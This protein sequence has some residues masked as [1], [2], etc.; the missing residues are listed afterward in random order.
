MKIALL[1]LPQSGKKTLFSLMTG[2]E[3]PEHRNEGDSL[4]GIA[5]IRDPRVDVLTEMENPEKTKYAENKIV[6]C[7]DMSEGTGK[8]EWLDAARRCDLLCLVVRDFASESVYHPSGS[9]DAARDRRALET[10]LL[11]ADLELIEKRLE[12][13]AKEKRSGLT[14][15]QQKEEEVLL[16]CREAVE[17]EKRISSLGFGEE[18]LAAIR[19]LNLV[20]L[21]PILWILNVEEERVGTAEPAGEDIFLISA[22]IEKEI[23]GIEETEERSEYLA[24]LGLDSSGLDRLNAAA[25]DALGLMSFYTMGKDEVRAWTIRKGSLAPAAGGKIHSDIERG[26]IRVEV[27]KYDDLVAAG[28]ESA[29]KAQGKALL[30]GKDYIMEDGDICHFRFNV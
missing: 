30:K 12:R 15:A 26:F 23:M 19:S 24:A 9:V 21:L 20:T 6:L 14:S 5:P 2:R 3:V 4:E 25:Y 11:L 16:T 13:I 18:D 8:R 17:N 27:I 29:A 28:S 1:G 22:L 7:P 10:E